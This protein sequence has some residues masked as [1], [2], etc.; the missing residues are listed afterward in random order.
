[1]T[2]SPADRPLRLAAGVLNQTPLDW[3]GNAA[4]VLRA[5]DDAR[6]LGCPWLCLPELC[7]TGYGCEDAFHAPWVW[8]EA[9]RVLLER[10]APAT[11][12]MLVAV[13]LPVFHRGALYNAAAV[14][15]DGEVVGLV[16]KQNLAGDG[17]HYEPRWF[18]AWPGGRVADHELLGGGRR[19]RSACRWATSCFPSRAA[20]RS[21]APA[22]ASRSAR[23]RGWPTGPAA[24]SPAAAST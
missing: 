24:G 15:C 3:D 20:V 6:R 21:T 5:I 9:S 1:M 2:A 13:G 14:C 4:R 17:L 12:G 11:T 23:T 19:R 16:A 18:K 10:I 22:W 7:L 8:A